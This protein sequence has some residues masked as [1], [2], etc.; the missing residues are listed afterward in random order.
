[1]ATPQNKLKTAQQY[2][3][4]LCQCNHVNVT[5]SGNAHTHFPFNSDQKEHIH[6]QNFCCV[7]GSVPK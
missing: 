5:A 7:T 6:R 1:M 2:M 4:S 3:Y